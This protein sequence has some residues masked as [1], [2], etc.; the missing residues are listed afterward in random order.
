MYHCFK[1]SP[2]DSDRQP[3]PDDQD[4]TGLHEERVILCRNCRHHITS[5]HLAV[6][7]EN[8]HQHTFFNPAGVLFEIGCFS[9]APGC[10]DTGTPTTEFAWFKDCSWRFSFCAQCNSHLGWQFLKPDGGE[11]HGLVLNRLTEEDLPL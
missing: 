8:K 3:A 4:Q 10:Q 2:G 1:Q 11:F 5:R 7:V 9:E 6:E